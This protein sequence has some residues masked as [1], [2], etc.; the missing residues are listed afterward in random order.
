M[1]ENKERPCKSVQD[2]MIEMTQLVLPNDANILGNLLGGRLMHWIDVAG[3]LTASS[4]LTV[5]LP[6]QHWTALISG[7]LSK[8]ARWFALSQGLHG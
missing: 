1:A 8:W 6:L 7:I 2:S 5:S 4:T 3:A